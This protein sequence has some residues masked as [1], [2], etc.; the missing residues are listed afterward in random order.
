MF[1]FRQLL[2]SVKELYLFSFY[3]TI[4]VSIA[5][6]FQRIYIYIFVGYVYYTLNPIRLG[7]ERGN[8]QICPIQH[9]FAITRV[10][11]IYLTY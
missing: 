1:G 11:L 9:I 7:G 3:P 2:F 4:L 8:L 10:Y 5:V 6:G